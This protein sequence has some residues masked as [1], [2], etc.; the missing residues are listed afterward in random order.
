MNYCLSV[1]N[2]TAELM[3]SEGIT[4]PALALTMVQEAAQGEFIAGGDV[5]VGSIV[6]LVD[7][8]TR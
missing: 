2:S 6:L 5:R 4:D 8:D 1:S 7:S 3:E